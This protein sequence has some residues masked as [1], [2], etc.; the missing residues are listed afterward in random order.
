MKYALA[1]S[2]AIIA[3]I[4]AAFACAIWLRPQLG[5]KAADAFLSRRWSY[6]GEGFPDHLVEKLS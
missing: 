5:T 3:S 6:C 1:H 4:L 2:G